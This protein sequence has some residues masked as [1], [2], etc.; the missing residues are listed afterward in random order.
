[1]VGFTGPRLGR[2]VKFFVGILVCCFVGMTVGF[3]VVGIS[4]LGAT[5]GRAALEEGLCVEVG[6]GEGPV[7][8]GFFGVG[9]LTGILVGSLVGFL[10]GLFEG[11]FVG[12]LVGCLV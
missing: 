10:V 8:A 12:I 9:L 11:F 7:V 3:F 6:A 2:L 4:L 5:V 1:L